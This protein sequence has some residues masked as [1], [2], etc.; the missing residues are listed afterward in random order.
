MAGDLESGKFSDGDLVSRAVGSDAGAFR[1]LYERYAAQM[2]AFLSGRAPRGMDPRELTQEVWL[3]AWRKLA[4]FDGRHFRGWLYKIA[5]NLL[6]D[7]YRKK[8][9]QGLSDNFDVEEVPSDAEP[10]ERMCALR[11]CLAELEDGFVAVL[12]AQLAGASVEDIAV[13]FS[14]ERGTVYTRVKR[15]KER[16]ENCVK[17]KLS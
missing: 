13:R 9:P 1:E 11:E 2:L 17:K 15:G 10:D 4:D 5:R 12:R 14:I 8:Q 3:R 7:T 6:K 16:L